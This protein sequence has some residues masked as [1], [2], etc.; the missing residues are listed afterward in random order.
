MRESEEN[1][2][3]MGARTQTL[4]DRLDY[5]GNLSSP[6]LDA[7]LQEKCH[8]IVQKLNADA[9]ELMSNAIKYVEDSDLRQNELCLNLGK[10]YSKIGEVNDEYKQNH[11]KMNFD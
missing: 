8:S 3:N 4:R 11:K 2:A 1:Y 6:E 10:F 9:R 7:L 5:I